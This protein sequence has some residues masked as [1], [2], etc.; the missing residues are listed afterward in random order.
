[1]QIYTT[2]ILYTLFI[3]HLLF[4]CLITIQHPP[5]FVTPF[6]TLQADL[7]T[8]T[9]VAADLSF[10][11]DRM[12]LNGVEIELNKR[13]RAVLQVPGICALSVTLLYHF[14][15]IDIQSYNSLFVLNFILIGDS[16]YCRR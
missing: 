2:A 5:S 1:M 15:S 7:R 11:K 3:M 6:H 12:W 8:I 13:A 14:Y 4:H 10:E 16:L 9:T